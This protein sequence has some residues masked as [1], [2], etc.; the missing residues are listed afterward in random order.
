MVQSAIDAEG[1]SARRLGFL[2]NPIAGL[3]GRVG[4]KGSDEVVEQA[5]ALGARPRSPR[6]A[7]EMLS[8]LREA[9][10]S[11][12]LADPRW[13]TCEGVMGADCL[14]R[15]GFEDIE[16]CHDP[17]ARLADPG[18]EETSGSEGST[19]ADTA[20]ATAAFVE[21]GAELVIFCGGDGTARDVH[22]AAGATPILGVPAGVKM[23]SGVFALSPRAAAW[24][25]I[26]YLQGEASIEDA[27]VLDLDEVRYREGDWSVR[28]FAIARTPRAH[29]LIQA[30]KQVIDEPPESVCKREIARH[31]VAQLAREL[32]GDA[33]VEELVILGPG[34][35]V[36]AVSDALGIKATLLGVDAVV[37]GDRQGGVDCRE[38]HL[39]V[40]ERRLL[41]LVERCSRRRLVLSPMGA[42]GFLLGR[43]NQQLSP[44]V[45]ASV[46][47]EAIVIAATPAKLRATRHLSLDTSDPELDRALFGSG[48][49]PVI[50]GYHQRRLVPVLDPDGPRSH[51]VEVAREPALSVAGVP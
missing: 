51:R 26:S 15:A 12:H 20:V 21:R 25:A 11:A 13:L 36:A 29:S 43:G 44:R 32:A 30:A 22:R 34:S 17:V 24:M 31:V 28:L 38:V 46:G 10:R 16:I 27:D 48:Y 7:L 41:D 19:A 37:V 1:P 45:V 47:R 2:I 39:D 8:T 35:T 49:L 9:L 14:R 5:L 3:G 4:L 18:C 50:T 33:D 40:D 42:S 6:R 23:Y